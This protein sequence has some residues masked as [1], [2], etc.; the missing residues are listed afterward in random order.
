MRTSVVEAVAVRALQGDARAQRP[1]VDQRD[2]GRRLRLPAALAGDQQRAQC[3][4][5]RVVAAAQPQRLDDCEALLRNEEA[6]R[7]GIDVDPRPRLR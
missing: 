1:A 2:A 5:Q 6:Q 7:A 4:G 3:A